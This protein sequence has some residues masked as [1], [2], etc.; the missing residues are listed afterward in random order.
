M[1]ELAYPWLLILLP[2]PW[3]LRYFL[4]AANRTSEAAL[5]VPFYQ[6]FVMLT[7]NQASSLGAGNDW[8]RYLIYLM[9]ICL[10][11][12]ACA[13]RYVGRPIELAQSGRAI[14]MALDVSGSMSIPDME[15]NHKSSNRLAVVKRLASTFVTQRQGDQ[16][17]LILFGSSAY[18]QTPLTFDLKTILAMLDDASVGLAGQQTAIGNAIGL[19]IKRLSKIP[20]K[21]R[22]LIVLTDGANNSGAINPIQAAK[23]AAEEHIKIYTIGLGAKRMLVPGLLGPQ[24]INPSANL[25]EKSLQ[26]IATVTK[27]QYFRAQDTKTL[28]KIY[29]TINKLEPVDGKK[30]IY[31]PITEFYVWPLAFFVMLGFILLW[32]KVV[33]R[34][35]MLSLDLGS[36]QS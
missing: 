35:R 12:A 32:L 2:A 9:W 18:L 23:L 26:K 10:I 16:L 30:S 31:R 5:C 21:S 34:P 29:Q 17:G 4:P 22:V 20:A 1:Y 14:M 15:W 24:V 13:P 7:S 28:K 19:G 11:L 8:K 33:R 36:E 3:L 6:R 27:G 25:D